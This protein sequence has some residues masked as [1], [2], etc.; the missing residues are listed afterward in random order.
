MSTKSIEIKVQTPRRETFVDISAEVARVVK[1]LGIDNGAVLVYCPHTTAG[2][3]I[4]ENAD[5]AVKSDI[6]KHLAK[7]IP[8][9]DGFDHMEGNSDS[10]IKASMMGSSCLVPLDNG[11]MRLGTWQS[12]YLTDFDGPRTRTVIIKVI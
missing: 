11:K 7:L 9:N 6:I 10:H 4:N 1:E 8:Q 5:P 2:I 3:T 12:I